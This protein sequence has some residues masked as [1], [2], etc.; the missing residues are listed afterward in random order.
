MRIVPRPEEVEEA[1]MLAEIIYSHTKGVCT[2]SGVQL[3]KVTKIIC[4][5]TQD[6]CEVYMKRGAENGVSTI[7]TCNQYVP[8]SAPFVVQ[9]RII[10]PCVLDRICA[11]TCTT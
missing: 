5:D 7:N 8:S 9:W 6:T 4:T 10:P 11:G 3:G 1:E 2:A